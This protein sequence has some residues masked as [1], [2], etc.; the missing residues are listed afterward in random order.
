VDG[1]YQARNGALLDFNTRSDRYV[2][3]QHIWKDTTDEFLVIGSGDAQVA[4][5][6]K[7]LGH[8]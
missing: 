6:Q 1:L 7:S 5:R 8:R 2:K 3:P 4:L